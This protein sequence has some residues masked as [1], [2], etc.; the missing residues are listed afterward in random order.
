MKPY[1]N[2]RDALQTKVALATISGAVERSGNTE[3]GQAW[4]S[5]V[6]Q[7]TC[8]KDKPFSPPFG[9]EL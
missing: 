9:T 2:E 3:A 6:K 8:E 5:V 7:V 4:A 1:V